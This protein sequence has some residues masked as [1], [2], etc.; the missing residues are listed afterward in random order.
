MS[1]QVTITIIIDD[2]GSLNGRIGGVHG[3][4]IY[5]EAC[6]NIILFDTGPDPGLLQRYSDLLGL[7]LSIIDAVVISHTHSDHIGGL[8]YIGWVSPHAKVYIP[9]A[10]GYVLEGFIRRQGLIPQEVLDWIAI[11][12]CIY[13]SKPFYGPPWE[14][15]LIVKGLKGLIVITGCAHKGIVDM[16]NEIMSFFKERK[17]YMVI[18][19]LHLSR[20]PRHIIEK[21]VEELLSRVEYVA[22]LHCSG[23]YV[24]KLLKEHG[25]LVDLYAGSKLTI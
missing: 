13:I 5:I 21:T 6:R 8:S 24:R 18:G 16:V 9:Y 14:H 11:N 15:A 12:S 23:D 20:A 1:E 19:G 10:S 3:L 4:S 22:P 2:R 7:D 25:R 17:I